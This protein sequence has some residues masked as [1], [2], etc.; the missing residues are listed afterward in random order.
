MDGSRPS[1]RADLATDDE[2]CA[3]SSY[4]YTLPFPH[5]ATEPN[6]ESYEYDHF[7]YEEHA[8]RDVIPVIN[9]AGGIYSL[10]PVTWYGSKGASF[11]TSG[12]SCAQVRKKTTTSGAWKTIHSVF[13]G[14]YDTG[15][16]QY[17]QQHCPLDLS[18]HDCIYFAPLHHREVRNPYQREVRTWIEPEDTQMYQC[19]AVCTPHNVNFDPKEGNT[20]S[21]CMVK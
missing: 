18:N 1:G 3:S 4:P 15:T 19:R 16:L 12:V 17:F 14:V 8:N 6:K 21:T 9:G 13:K 20:C 2:I 5:T 11:R 10:G 7:D